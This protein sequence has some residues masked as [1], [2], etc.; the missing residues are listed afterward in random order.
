M[1]QTQ[2]SPADKERA[3]RA[4]MNRRK[5]RRKVNNKRNAEK[6][7]FEIM[8]ENTL[9]L[10]DPLK[11][12][13]DEPLSSGPRLTKIKNKITWAER[14]TRPSG[15]GVKLPK[16]LGKSY[17]LKRKLKEDK[18]IEEKAARLTKTPEKKKKAVKE[19]V[20]DEDQ[21]EEVN[22][23][24][25]MEDGEGDGDVQMVE[26]RP[27]KRVRVEAKKVEEKKSIHTILQ[28]STTNS[29]E[30]PD[31]TP[32]IYDLWA[33][34]EAAPVKPQQSFIHEILHPEEKVFHPRKLKSRVA[35]VA[36]PLAAQSYRPTEDSHKE[37]QKVVAKQKK[38]IEVVKKK[39]EEIL[40]NKEANFNFYLQVDK[41]VEVSKEEEEEE[42]GPV[43]KQKR[44][45]TTKEKL[46]RGLKKFQEAKLKKEI[47]KAEHEQEIDR[48]D[49]ILAE[50]EEKEEKGAKKHVRNIINKDK[51]L[52]KWGTTDGKRVRVMPGVTDIGEFDPRVRLST[53]TSVINPVTERF[54]SLASR[55]LAG[56]KRKKGEPLYTASKKPGVQDSDDEDEEKY[57]LPA[58]EKQVDFLLSE[59]NTEH[60]V[61][62]RRTRKGTIMHEGKTALKYLKGDAKK[63]FIK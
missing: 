62:L 18:L 10:L 61:A 39:S 51:R 6:L 4:R 15:L 36:I 32:Q 52:D 46:K 22:E 27:A 19:E 31:D 20:A 16:F 1:G 37:L 12:K 34:K 60:P 14:T 9:D 50:I 13:Q 26:E 21:N 41:P 44:P 24:D 57:L 30:S 3:K 43:A 2:V 11:N 59:E 38:S 42:E 28:Q 55:G 7:A 48:V 5:N 29:L 49:E 45:K 47:E 53:L 54:L 56:K 23:G 8:E 40:G 17:K 58:Y 63:K 33:K 35:P 25:K